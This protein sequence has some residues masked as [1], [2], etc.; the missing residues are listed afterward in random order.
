MCGNSELKKAIRKTNDLKGDT[1]MMDAEIWSKGIVFNAIKFN[2]SR[3]HRTSLLGVLFFAVV[4]HGRQ[5]MTN[6]TF[7]SFTSVLSILILAV[8]TALT[9]PAQYP[10]GVKPRLAGSA[11][12]TLNG[13]IRIPKAFGIVPK[14]PGNSQG[15]VNPCGQFYVAV[16]DPEKGN[17]PIALADS[18]IEQGRDDGDFYTCKYSLSVP[19]NKR[20]FA[21]AGMGGALLLPKEDRD[22]MYITD[23]WIGG[24]NNKPRRGYERG[25]AGKFVT[26]GTVKAMYLKFDMYYAQVDPN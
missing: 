13:V 18:T 6:K 23:A 5:I 25:F 17:R 26:L 1:N 2:A 15:A 8:A 10:P 19:A 21:I 4:T 22:P 7:K 20:L 24:T 14:G 11:E 12:Q 9:V 16:L 3:R